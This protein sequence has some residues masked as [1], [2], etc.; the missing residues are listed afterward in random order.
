MDFGAF[1]TAVTIVAIQSVL[2]LAL[3]YHFTPLYNEGDRARLF[4]H[5]DTTP[6][7]GIHACRAG[8]REVE[9]G[10]RGYRKDTGVWSAV[11]Q[12]GET[13]AA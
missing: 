1:L 8:E 10:D 2:V 9:P 3:A 13:R 4:G 11:S 7:K 5:L 6:P 12:T